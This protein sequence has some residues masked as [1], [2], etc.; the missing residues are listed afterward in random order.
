MAFTRFFLTSGAA[1]II[2]GLRADVSTVSNAREV[3][4]TLGGILLVLGVLAYGSEP[5]PK[6]RKATS[7]KQE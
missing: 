7:V 3:M 5:E 2:T 1:F 4:L 6:K